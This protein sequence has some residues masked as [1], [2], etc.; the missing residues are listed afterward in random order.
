MIYEELKLPLPVYDRLEKQYRFSKGSAINIVIATKD[1][2]LPFQ[3]ILNSVIE[4]SDITSWTINKPDAAR[5]EAYDLTSKITELELVETSAGRTYILYKGTDI[6]LLMNHGIYHLEFVINDLIYFSEQFEVRCESPMWDDIE[7]LYTRIDWDNN[8]CDFG[9][10][11]YQT[12]YKNRAYLDTAIHK[13][14]PTIEEEGSNDG[15]GN[16]VAVLQKYIDNLN[17]EYVCPFYLADALVLMSIH[18]NKTL[19]TPNTLYSADIKNVKPT[20]VQEDGSWNYRI[21]IPFQQESTYINAA[22]CNNIALPAP[23]AETCD[24]SITN[25]VITEN[26]G[27]NVSVTW[28]L[29]GDCDKITLGWGLG[30]IDCPAAGS[31]DIM[32]PDSMTGYSFPS[33]FAKGTLII[34]LTPKCLIAGDYHSGTA[35]PKTKILVKGPNCSDI[36]EPPDPGEGTGLVNVENNTTTMPILNITGIPGYTCPVIPPLSGN[37]GT[38][39]SFPSG[40]GTIRI[41]F[42]DSLSSFKNAQVKVNGTL[43]AC[44]YLGSSP[45]TMLFLAPGTFDDTDDITISINEGDCP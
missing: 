45:R 15:A 41:Y 32:L 8:N 10:I 37:S 28:D 4:S 2:I 20:V 11:L 22:C 16:F 9:P 33:P 12:G 14:T 31:L 19:T 25:V 1:R 44:N 30:N 17:L 13:E 40:T 39:T 18:K 34:T 27:G 36:P 29:L 42:D 35:V 7:S 3:F 26:D 6:G 5:T 21:T 38:H 24:A 43:I 23:E